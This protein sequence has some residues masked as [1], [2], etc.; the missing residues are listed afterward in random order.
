M[1]PSD[2]H[3]EISTGSPLLSIV[4]AVEMWIDCAI[5]SLRVNDIVRRSENAGRRGQAHYRAVVCISPCELD[6][7]KFLVAVPYLT[8]AVGDEDWGNAY[9]RFLRID[10]RNCLPS[11][12]ENKGCLNRNCHIGF[13]FR[14]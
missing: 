5:A 13:C 14:V 3:T 1:E 6:G 8:G 12:G 11:T 7:V 10:A 2:F 4:L 9:V